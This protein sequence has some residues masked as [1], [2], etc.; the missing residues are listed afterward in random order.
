MPS[1]IRRLASPFFPIQNLPI[2]FPSLIPPIVSAETF[3]SLICRREK[4]PRDGKPV[5]SQSR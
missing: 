4:K 2:T 3:P 5:A 1:V